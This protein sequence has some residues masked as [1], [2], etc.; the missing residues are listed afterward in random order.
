MPKAE[1]THHRAKIFNRPLKEVGLFL[2]DI[3][4]N[5][6]IIIVLVILIRTFL[7][8]PFRVIGSS[9]SDTLENNEFI[10][11]DKL[12][13]RLGEP[14]R[15]DPIVFLPPIT[16]KYPPKFEEPVT[17]DAS[18][19]GA[20]DIRNLTTPKDTFYCHNWLVQ[21]F[22]FCQ[23]KV[24]AGDWVYFLDIGNTTDIKDEFN[25]KVAK[26]ET[27]SSDDLKNGSLTFQ[28]SPNRSYLVRVYGHTGPEYFVKRIIGIPGDTVRIENGLVYVKKSG[29]TDFTEL[30]ENYLN[31]ENK[32][33]TFYKPSDDDYDF[34]VPAD[35]YFVLGDNR[36]HSNDS[37]QWFSPI[38][39][40]LTPFVD[41]NDISGKVMVVLW[42][43]SNLGLIP[44]GVLQ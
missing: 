30:T 20:L 5:A 26:K 14:K 34:V 44:G 25:W 24:L 19:N 23:D 41:L 17:T 8:S 3:L 10:L 12:S 9:M 6:V 31:S 42:P 38:D 15:G 27:A 11:I 29:D 28:G 33:N 37:R 39:D 32:N 43:P 7:I 18:G 21:K 16:N 35:H 13:Y 22:W 1:K 40:S 36:T 2:L 4:Y